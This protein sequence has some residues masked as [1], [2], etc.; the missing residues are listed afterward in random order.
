M[1]AQ[2][3]EFLVT[4]VANLEAYIRDIESI[5]KTTYIYAVDI[6]VGAAVKALED[7]AYMGITAANLFPGLDGI[8]KMIQQQMLLKHKNLKI[9]ANPNLPSNNSEKDK[10]S[11]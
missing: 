3:G 6:P 8:S 4:N 2:Q 10:N 5:D 11:Y 7:L 1:Y 9:P